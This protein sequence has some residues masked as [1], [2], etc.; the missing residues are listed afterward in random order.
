MQSTGSQRGY[1]PAGRDPVWYGAGR[2][3]DDDRRVR[4]YRRSGDTVGKT[5]SYANLKARRIAELN[6]YDAI[7]EAAASASNI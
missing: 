1:V 7:D 3:Y 6:A 4:C 2:I 5:L